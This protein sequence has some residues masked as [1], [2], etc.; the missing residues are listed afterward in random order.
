MKYDVN[1]AMRPDINFMMEQVIDSETGMYRTESIMADPDTGKVPNWFIM[2]V[3]KD[4]YYCEAMAPN[5]DELAR[6]FHEGG[7]SAV[8]NFRAA[9]FDC[10]DEKNLFMC[11]YMHIS[12]LPK[13]VVLR[14]NTQNKFF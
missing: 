9:I 3:M 1:H 8:A 4:C 14:P 2:F 6:S 13:F 5:M 11:Q 12:R 10:S 7:K